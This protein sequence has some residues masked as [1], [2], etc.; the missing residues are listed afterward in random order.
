MTSEAINEFVLWLSKKEES[1]QR[2]KDNI[3]DDC[4]D[5]ER[6]EDLLNSQIE[7]IKCLK[8]DLKIEQRRLNK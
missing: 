5:T 7:L 6:V 2:I 8:L 3:P 4:Y 1:L